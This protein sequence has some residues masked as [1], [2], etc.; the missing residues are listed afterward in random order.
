MIFASADL[1]SRTRENNE[2]KISLPARMLQACAALMLIA[3]T[4]STG[5]SANLITLEDYN[6]PEDLLSCSGCSGFVGLNPVTLSS[7]DADAY[8]M[9]GNSNESSQ[10]GL[11]NDLLAL[12]D[13]ARDPVVYANKTDGDGSGF[14]TDRQ[15]FSIKK[16]TKMWF[17]ENLTGGEI[18]VELGDDTE[19]YSNWTAYG[20]EVPKV[21]VPAAFWL[22]GTALIGLVGFGRRKLS[23]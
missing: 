5:V 15:F 1:E 13:P 10:L 11:L 4:A 12:F 14:K 2:M 7:S 20:P 21:P 18:T 19:P 23:K 8:G 9:P 6:G 3:G 17:F 16:A 22:F